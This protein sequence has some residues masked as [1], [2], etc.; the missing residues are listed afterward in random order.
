MNPQPGPLAPAFPRADSDPGRPSPVPGPPEQ[1]VATSAML[2]M[3][4]PSS[5]PVRRRLFC[6]NL[7]NP[8]RSLP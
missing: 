8:P 6:H 5:A 7:A 3:P 1:V 4:T 2:A